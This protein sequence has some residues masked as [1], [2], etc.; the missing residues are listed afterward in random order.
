MKRMLVLTGA[1]LLTLALA[2][3]A[4]AAKPIIYFDR[5]YDDL[6]DPFFDLCDFGVIYQGVGHESYREWQDTSG[7][8]LMGLYE[9]QGTDSFINEMTGT[10]V[11]GKFHLTSHLSDWTRDGVNDTWAWQEQVTGA[12]WNIQ[13]PKEGAVFHESGH[14]YQSVFAPEEDADTWIYT[15]SRLI[16]NSTFD[17]EALCEALAAD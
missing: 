17:D 9:N 15:V 3:P 11:S 4:A 5:D 12:W 14:I 7:F 6:S 13:L 10:T 1:L 16:G 2:A 8:P